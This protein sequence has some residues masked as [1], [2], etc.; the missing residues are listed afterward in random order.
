MTGR[1]LGRLWR[2]SGTPK[3]N[4]AKVEQVFPLPLHSPC[5]EH[6]PDAPDPSGRSLSWSWSWSYH[7]WLPIMQGS[8]LLSRHRNPVRFGRH[9][10]ITK[11]SCV[12]QKTLPPIDGFQ[13]SSS[14]SSLP[15]FATWDDRRNNRK[16]FSNRS[17]PLAED[18][19]LKST[20]MCLF[21]SRQKSHSF[22]QVIRSHLVLSKLSQLWSLA[23][24]SLTKRVEILILSPGRSNGFIDRPVEGFSYAFSSAFLRINPVGQL[25]GQHMDEIGI[26]NLRMGRQLSYI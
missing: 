3:K 16:L 6:H 18:Q 25:V 4:W 13:R 2:G 17:H 15:E 1:S 7:D 26:S 12:S 5:D 21:V 11:V 8:N 23:M 10:Y 22:F 24:V 9:Y 20:G 14:D 19:V